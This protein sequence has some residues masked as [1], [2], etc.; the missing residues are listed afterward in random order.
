M[1]PGLLFGFFFAMGPIMV[2]YVIGGINR[3]GTVSAVVGKGLT[4]PPI[5]FFFTSSIVKAAVNIIGSRIASENRIQ[6]HELIRFLFYSVIGIAGVLIAFLFGFQ[7]QIAQNL[8]ASKNSLVP[9]FEQYVIRF[10][11]IAVFGILTYCLAYLYQPLFSSL[12]KIK[13]QFYAALCFFTFLVLSFSLYA[14][15]GRNDTILTKVTVFAFFY[16]LA[17][18]VQYLFYLVY[19]YLPKIYTFKFLPYNHYRLGFNIQSQYN[20]AYFENMKA[21]KQL[22]YQSRFLYIYVEKNTT[23]LFTYFH[24]GVGFR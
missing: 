16:V 2:S 11:S 22:C 24:T 17:Y 19:T 21:I 12:R 10:N 7:N 3:D 8:L 6:L 4:I 9:N 5:F 13:E 1:L 15:A 14:Y 18:F 23:N 20:T